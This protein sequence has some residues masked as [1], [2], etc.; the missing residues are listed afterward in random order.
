MF[1][2]KEYAKQYREKNKEIIKSKRLQKYQEDREKFLKIRRE[3]YWKNKLAISARRVKERRTKEF[4]EK[5]SL[6]R[7]KYYKKNIEKERQ[8]IYKWKEK[9]KKKSDI[10]AFVMYAVK[11][12][13]LKKPNKCSKCNKICKIQGHHKDYEKPLDVIWLCAIC[14]GETH[15]IYR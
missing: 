5:N 13:Y 8:R 1:N 4:K 12:G 3:Y 6:Y 14:H 2:A 9:N 11:T 15:R 7:K 10:H